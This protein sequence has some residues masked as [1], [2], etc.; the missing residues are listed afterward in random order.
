MGVM[1][2]FLFSSRNKRNFW[3][4]LILKT[5]KPELLFMEGGYPFHWP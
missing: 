2:I 1:L 5:G 4:S 3:I